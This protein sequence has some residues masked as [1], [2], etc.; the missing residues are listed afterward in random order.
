MFTV[1]EIE[2]E[3]RKIIGVCDDAKFFRWVGDALSIIVNKGDFEGL[4]GDID[5]C[6][7]GC[8]CG[9]TPATLCRSANCGRKLIALP[10]DVETVIAVNIGGRPTL[11]FGQ[12]FSY[13]LNGPG[14]CHQS[15]DWSWYDQ[16]GN[17]PTF[18]E[19]VTPSKLV[20]HLQNQ[21]DNGKK[22]LIYG[23]DNNGLLLRRKVGDVWE[24]GW[25]APTIYGYA[26]PDTQAP[27]IS[28]IT[29]IFKER[30]A[31][32]MRL[33]T[34]D[35]SGTTGV[36]LGI[37]EPDEEIPQLRR[38]K[39]NRACN[40]VRIAYTKGASSFHSRYDHI[41]LASR[42]AF[43]L[44]VQAR[45]HYSD[46]QWSEAHAAEADAARL[47]IEAQNKKEAPLYFPMQVVD[48]NNLRDKG[49][50]DAIR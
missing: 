46:R 38:I 44:A 8:S 40:W 31:G 48:R 5:I 37:Y 11:G 3:S 42:L 12:L 6:T 20:V 15:C 32:S 10:R 13:H 25:Q 22:F 2:D 34:T 19:L 43:L 39:I 41:P 1:A 16:G 21:E 47:E 30:S 36:T 17:H 18:R 14:D 26:I 50:F 4:K 45:K 9:Q 24:N 33:S 28:R 27:V 29:G 7:T 49:E 23:Y 35:D